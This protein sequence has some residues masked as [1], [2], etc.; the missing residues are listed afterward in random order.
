VTLVEAIEAQPYWFHRID[1]G[2]GVVTPGWNDPATT[3]LPYFGLPDS[4]AGMRVLDVGCSEGFFSFEAERRGAAE[5]VSVDDSPAALQRFRI[6]AGVLGSPIEPNCLSVYDLDP[7]KL[8]TFDLVMFFGVLYHLRYPLLGM[9]KVAGMARRTVLVQ[10][11][12][13][14][15]SKWEAVPMSRFNRDGVIS[16]PPHNRIR[17]TTVLWEP[18]AACLRDMLANVGLAD[19]ER[20]GRRPPTARE[21]ITRRLRSTKYQTW[22]SGAQFRGRVP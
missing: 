10:S 7:S 12:T 21:S 5:V 8:G 6:C 20:I 11:R 2:N 4:M 15:S 13:F 22:S 9:E 3:K 14:E 16:G 1:L 17:D 19:I 18:N